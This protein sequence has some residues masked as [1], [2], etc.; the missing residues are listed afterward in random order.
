MNVQ[1]NPDSPPE[2]G[3]CES[4]A[5]GSGTGYAL[6]GRCLGRHT[7][8]WRYVCETQDQVREHVAPGFSLAR[9]AG[10]RGMFVVSA[11]RRTTQGPGF[12]L[13]APA[14]VDS[15]PEADAA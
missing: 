1:A 13:Q 15:G 2:G 4:C 14:L 6:C 12:W 7:E 3:H 10:I 8:V 9:L 11:F 5:H